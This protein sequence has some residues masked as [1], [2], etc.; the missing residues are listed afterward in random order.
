M[1]RDFDLATDDVVALV[2][3]RT[4]T[5]RSG[6]P[7]VSLTV[8]S[9]ATGEQYVVSSV[10][11]Y[12]ELKDLNEGSRL[13]IKYMENGQYRNLVK[14]IV[15]RSADGLAQLGWPR[16][17]SDTVV[18]SVEEPELALDAMMHEWSERISFLWPQ[19]DG[20]VDIRRMSN[21]DLAEAISL[22][23]RICDE[24]SKKKGENDASNG[25]G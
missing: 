3:L 24:R 14:V 1:G 11:L 22:L 5:N 21:D 12:D 2:R 17:V 18:L 15:R 8:R 4:D 25:K 16:P 9:E 6:S 13:A 23:T 7:R 19:G 20:N 10:K